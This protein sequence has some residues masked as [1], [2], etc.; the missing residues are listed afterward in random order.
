MVL[1]SPPAPG[2]LQSERRH[3]RD[4]HAA[5]LRSLAASDAARHVNP[6][7]T[8]RG[9]RIEPF[10][11]ELGRWRARISRLDGTKLRSGRSQHPF[12][13]TEDAVLAEETIKLA[14]RMIDRCEIN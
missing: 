2:E 14:K 13:D 12:I 7:L 11:P 10:E 1:P 8:H 5:I 4:A 6:M 3:F 9:Y